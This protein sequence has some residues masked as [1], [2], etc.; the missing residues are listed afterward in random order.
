[1]NKYEVLYILTASLAD[2]EKENLINKFADLVTNA[3]GEVLSIDKWGLRK[4]AYPIDYKNEGYY[5]LMNFTA[6]AELPKEM[7]RVMRIADE[8]MRYMVIRKK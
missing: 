7:E 8:V 6:N 3:G 5:V 4:L 1:M 2:E